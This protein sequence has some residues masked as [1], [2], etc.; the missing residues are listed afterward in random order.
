VNYQTVEIE[1]VD[2]GY[3]LSIGGCFPFKGQQKKVCMSF[4]DLVE[5]LV[6]E[7]DVTGVRVS[8]LRKLYAGLSA[9][10]AESVAKATGLQ[11]KRKSK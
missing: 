9:K 8:G 1:K 10:A 7:F 3:V 2:N 6:E 11:K 5:L 4:E